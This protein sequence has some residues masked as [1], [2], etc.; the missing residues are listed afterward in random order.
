VIAALATVLG[1]LWWRSRRKPTTTLPNGLTVHSWQEG[2]T[3]YLYTEIFADRSYAEEGVDY[4]SARQIVDVGANIGMFAIWA[5]QEAPRAKILSLEPVPVVHA[6]LCA[7]AKRHGGGRITAL[8]TGASSSAGEVEFDFHPHF[9]LWST[10]ERGFDK[11]RAERLGADLPTILQSSPQGRW[12]P[13]PLR[14]RM[15]RL[16]LRLMNRTSKVRCKLCRLSDALAANGITEVDVLKVDVEGHELDVLR[17]VDEGDWPKIKSVVMECESFE[18]ARAI[19]ELLR[20]AGFASVSWKPS[21][22]I[23]VTGISSE[24][25][26]L[27]AVRNKSL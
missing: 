24:V 22:R 2:E 15:A 17:G 13:A 8:N 27:V 16:L 18:N 19:E 7:N 12:I 21:E 23:K 20:S 14:L 6:V 4:A 9:S 10:A 11:S 5:A 26:S 1:L 25:C 3:S